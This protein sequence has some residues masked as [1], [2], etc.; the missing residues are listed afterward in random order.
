MVALFRRLPEGEWD[1]DV[2]DADEAIHRE[3]YDDGVYVLRHDQ[4]KTKFD[5]LGKHISKG[6]ANANSAASLGQTAGTKEEELAAEPVDDSDCSGSH[7]SV[8]EDGG[9]VGG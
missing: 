8:H 6:F 7:C 3:T 2:E 5:F 4:L 9:G 1:V